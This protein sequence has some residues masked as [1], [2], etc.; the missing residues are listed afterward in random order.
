MHG[1]GGAPPRVNDQQW[2]NQ[3]RLYEPAEGIVVA[4]RAPGNT[5]DLWHQGHVDPLFDE[6]IAAYVATQDVDPDRVYLM[7]YSAG[8]DGVYQLAPR[9]ADRFAAASMMAGHPN[10]SQPLGL[11]NLP[12]GLFVGEKDSAYN[13]NKVAMDYGARLD[14]LQKEDPHGYL[15]WMK[16]HPDKPHWMGG[17]DREAVAWMLRYRRETSPK[18][19]VWFQ[20]DVTHASFYWMSHVDGT[21][22]KAGEKIIA[23]VQ[24]NKI[25]IE[26]DVASPLRLWLSDAL[27]DL[28]KPIEVDWNGKQVFSGKVDRK[29]ANMLNSLLMH[30]DPQRMYP[31]MVEIKP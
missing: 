8:G 2:N 12:F 5:W 27:V 10:E 11:R 16:L 24:G 4:P 17:E 28:E 30:S 20:D 15:H 31:G 9:M 6:L 19:V 26:T 13:R 25:T 29:I 21:Q 22:P 18:K 23:N 3:I 7:G 1:G 14:A